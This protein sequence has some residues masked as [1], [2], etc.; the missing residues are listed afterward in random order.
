[1]NQFSKQ[2]LKLIIQSLSQVV[3]SLDTSCKRLITGLLSV[4]WLLH[5]DIA[6]PYGRLMENLVS[7]HTTHA[8]A[9]CN[10]LIGYLVTGKSMCQWHLNNTYTRSQTLSSNSSSIAL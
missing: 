8:M 5:S 6:A 2:Q 1:M 10:M 9:V 4:E 7:A 3:S